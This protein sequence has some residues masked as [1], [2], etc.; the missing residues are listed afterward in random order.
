[1]SSTY[2]VDSPK[3]CRFEG[4]LIFQPGRWANMSQAGPGSMEI[5]AVITFTPLNKYYCHWAYFHEICLLM[6]TT[7]G[8]S[9]T[10]FHEKPT[11]VLTSSIKSQ[12][13]SLYIKH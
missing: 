13:Y 4:A 1:M 10:E 8:K 12:T 11:D 6:I 7:V 5:M 2:F 9:Y 3:E